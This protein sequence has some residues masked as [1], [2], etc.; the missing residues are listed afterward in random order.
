MQ[1][2]VPTKTTNIQGQFVVINNYNN[3]TYPA[4]FPPA[5]QPGAGYNFYQYPPPPPPGQPYPPYYYP[6]TIPTPPPPSYFPYKPN[7]AKEPEKVQE[8][9]L[10]KLL[11]KIEVSARD[12]AS[13]RLLQKKLEEGGKEF[14]EKIFDRLVSDIASYMNDP[15][16]NYLCQKLFEQCDTSQIALVIEHVASQVVAIA[17]DLHGTRA[18][19]KVIE[20]SVCDPAVLDKVISVLKGHI[21]QLVMDNNGNH[22]VQQCLI[23]IKAPSNQFIYEEIMLNCLAI[24]THKHGCCV[25]QKCIDY[26][27]ETQKVVLQ[28]LILK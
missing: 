6:Y 23:N 1:P 12:Q 2:I 26:S 10:D 25:L 13:C 18:I 8:V 17:T 19:Q 15:F 21:A 24:A 28:Q 14:R 7:E 16:A 11:A 20:K 4:P 5:G 22:V 9:D 27:D 3:Y